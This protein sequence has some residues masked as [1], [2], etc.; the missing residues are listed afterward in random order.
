MRIII[1]VDRTFYMPSLE[2]FLVPA[3]YY[4]EVWG[5]YIVVLLS[6]QQAC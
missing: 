6:V 5:I 4:Q 1:D 2:F 3:V